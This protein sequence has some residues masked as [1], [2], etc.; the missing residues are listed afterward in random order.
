MAK[1]DEINEPDRFPGTP[2]P[3]DQFTLVGHKNGEEAFIESFKSGK[4]HHAWLITGAPGI[5][6]ATLAYR[7]ARY[8]LAHGAQAPSEGQG[9]ALSPDHPV[10]RQVSALSHPNLVVLRRT[11]SP[12]RK[13][14]PTVISVDVARKGMSLFETTAADGDFRICIIDSADDLN[15]NSAN[16]LLKMVEEPPPNSLFL[17]ISHAPQRLLPTIRSRCRRLALQPLSLNETAGIITSL[18]EPFSSVRGTTLQSAL[19]YGEGSVRKTLEMLDDSRAAII[20]KVNGILHDLPI[21]DTQR[22]MTLADSLAQRD[23]APEFNLAME[24]VE[25]WVTAK[26][27]AP[28]SVN[29]RTLAQLVEICEK[30]NKTMREVDVYNLDRRPLVLWLF[31]ELA[32]II[33]RM[34]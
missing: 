12:D 5:G 34:V 26:L 3:K 11:L 14:M 19:T 30:L 20:A 18:G 15:L 33:R 28:A 29:V 17:F 6:K 7:V 24:C 23:A 4:L 27:H 31:D 8:I 10:S 32:Q 22:V 21:V 1:T 2:H 13:T 25:R 9:L 16:A